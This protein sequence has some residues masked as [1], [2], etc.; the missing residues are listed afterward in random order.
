MVILECF[1]DRVIQIAVIH[2]IG[3]H[4]RRGLCQFTE[5]PAQILALLMGA[6]RR[7]RQRSQLGVDLNEQFPQ[8]AKIQ[9][10]ASILVVLLKEFVEAAEMVRSLREAFPD[11][12]GDFAPFGEG[13]V[14]LFG[15]FALFDGEGAK[16]GD[17]VI[18]DIVLDRGAVADGVNRA[19]RGAV[20]AEVGV[21]L[22][23]VAVVLDL[24]LRGDAF[25][26]ISLRYTEAV[27]IC[28]L[29]AVRRGYDIPTPV[30]HRQ[31]PCGNSLVMVS[32]FPSFCVKRIL[33]G[34]TSLT[35]EFVRTS[36]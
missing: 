30:D 4:P 10:P 29:P 9:G 36:T 20:E 31:K 34:R 35:R 33:S 26:E 7:S 17:E 1:V 18:G 12:L 27:S 3:R 14:H 13:D 11:P 21:G 16:E 2:F 22:Q 24:K 19:E 25:A 15:V 8:F 6:L 23:G 32:P 5:F 28:T